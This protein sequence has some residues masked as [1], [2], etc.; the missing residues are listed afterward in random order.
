MADITISISNDPEWGW[1]R[2]VLLYREQ[3]TTLDG[4]DYTWLEPMFKPV[5]NPARKTLEVILPIEVKNTQGEWEN[6]G[7][8]TVLQATNSDNAQVRRDP[9]TGAMVHRLQLDDGTAGPNGADDVPKWAYNNEQR[10]WYVIPNSEGKDYVR[11]ENN[12]P[13][14]NPAFATAMGEYTYM[15]WIQGK[16]L[17]E[18]AGTYNSIP[19][20]YQN[21]VTALR[22]TGRFDF[23]LKIRA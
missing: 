23:P 16:P 21:L 14:P 15:N 7:H 20:Y 3:T 19:D 6:V 4:T 22:D 12:N 11:D 17:S 2:R 8:N 18:L 10:R 13:V 9:A 1:E 5:Y